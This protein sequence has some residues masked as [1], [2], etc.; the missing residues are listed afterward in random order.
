L[1]APPHCTD[2]WTDGVSRQSTDATCSAAAAATLLRAHDIPATEREMA[3]LC[4]TRRQGTNWQGLYRGLKL[5]T[6][7]TP[8]DVEVFHCNLRELQA[9]LSG[10]AILTVQLGPNQTDQRYIDDFGWIPGLSH[11]AVL[12]RFSPDGLLV[13]MGDPSVGREEWSTDDLRILW[14]GKGMR[15]VRRTASM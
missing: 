4:L 1:G 5:K 14:T 3:E 2:V 10:P 15:L 8:W 6:A 11:S 13:E 12:F 9:T 7:G